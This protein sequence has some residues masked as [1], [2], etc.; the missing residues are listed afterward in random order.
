MTAAR[1]RLVLDELQNNPEQVFM[2]LHNVRLVDV[3]AD[4]DGHELLHVEGECGERAALLGTAK[5]SEWRKKEIG[6]IG[7]VRRADRRWVEA[8]SRACHFHAYPDQ[9]LRRAPELDLMDLDEPSIEGRKQNVIGWR[10]DARGGFRAPIG[11]TPGEGGQFIEDRSVSVTLRVPHEFVEECK[12]YGMTPAEMLQGFAGD[13]SGI[14]NYV[15][16]PRA[17]GFGSNGSDERDMADAW[18]QRAYFGQFEEAEEAAAEAERREEERERAEERAL[19][20][21]DFGWLLHEWMDAGGDK[22]ELFNTVE[23]LVRSKEAESESDAGDDAGEGENG[24][25]SDTNTGSN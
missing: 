18:M 3:T 8:P 11:L 15:V 14:M 25:S 23:Q 2:T 21:D 1:E 12:R 10:C 4:D 13:A 7:V 16:N 17:D 24:R 5:V 22:D 6:Q 9:S 19:E 20:R